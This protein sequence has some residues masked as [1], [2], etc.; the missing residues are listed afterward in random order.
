MLPYA[1]QKLSGANKKSINNMY[2]S[3]PNNK[4]ITEIFNFFR[5]QME[6]NTSIN[7]KNHQILK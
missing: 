3:L 1:A 6:S 7:E 5:S 2:K 4:S